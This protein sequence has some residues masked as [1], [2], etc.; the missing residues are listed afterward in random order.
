MKVNTFTEKMLEAHTQEAT[1]GLQS[2]VNRTRMASY[3][4]SALVSAA[5]TLRQDSNK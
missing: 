2:D 3:E 5:T 4:F 1:T